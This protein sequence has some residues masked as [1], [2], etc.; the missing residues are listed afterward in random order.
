MI[1][2]ILSFK[3]VSSILGVYI[4]M[5]THKDKSITAIFDDGIFF[6]FNP[7]SNELFY[8]DTTETSVIN[9]TSEN[10]LNSLNSYSIVQPVHSNKDLF[11][12]KDI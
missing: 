10:S 9:N 2:N 8:F 11:I 5:D 4:T 7:Y 12:V 3:D 6:M 1:A